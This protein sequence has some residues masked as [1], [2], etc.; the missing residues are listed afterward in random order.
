MS[1]FFYSLSAL[2]CFTCV[3]ISAQTPVLD[4]LH[5]ALKT[6]KEDT[7]KIDLLFELAGS[8]QPNTSRQYAETAYN[9]AM[10]LGDKRRAADAKN[11]IAYC[12]LDM[13][14][15]SESQKAATEA[16][17]LAQAIDNKRIIAY[18]Y[19]TLSNVDNAQ[20]NLDKALELR[21]KVLSM[22]EEAG[23]LPGKAMALTGIGGIYTDMQPTPMV[24]AMNVFIAN[25][26]VC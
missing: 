1:H 24:L 10:R 7:A 4:S 23:S 18:A 6:A 3:A 22:A 20:G 12:Y 14:N 19:M 16:L 21:F 17:A 13:S 9:L 8:T 25:G 5:N 26:T 15:F 2:L 11:W